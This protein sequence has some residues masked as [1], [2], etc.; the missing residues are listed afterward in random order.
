MA[1]LRQ[2]L[3]DRLS[4]EQQKS[5]GERDSSRTKRVRTCPGSAEVHTTQ[6]A[7]TGY[8]R[9]VLHALTGCGTGGPGHRA[10]ARA[11]GFTKVRAIAAATTRIPT[12]NQMALV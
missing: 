4:P 11:P 7:L 1:A 2:T 8:R 12:A 10:A 6:W 3:F 5:L 9:L